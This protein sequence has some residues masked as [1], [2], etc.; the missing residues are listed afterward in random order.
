IT[1]Q[2][3]DKLLD[4][5][6]HLLGGCLKRWQTEKKLSAVFVQ[7]EKKI[8]GEAFDQIAELESKKIK[9]SDIKSN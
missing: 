4:S 2:L 7:E 1:L 6:G 8:V 5:N 9:A 3:W